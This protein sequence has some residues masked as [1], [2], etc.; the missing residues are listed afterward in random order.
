MSQPI[1]PGCGGKVPEDTIWTWGGK[2]F[3][4]QQCAEMVTGR[5]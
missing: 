5:Q 1:C 2:A 4:S 3:C